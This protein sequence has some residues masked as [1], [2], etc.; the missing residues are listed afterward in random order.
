MT[1]LSEEGMSKTKKCPKL[2]LLHQRVIQVMNAKEKFLKEIKSAAPVNTQMIRKWN[3]LIAD[4]EKVWV[5]WIEDQTSH[6]I[7]WSQSL[8]QS[9]DLIL[10]NLRKA[11]RGEEAAEGKFETSKGWLMRF[12]E[13]NHLYNVKVQEETVN[14]DIE[15]AESCPEDITK[16]MTVPAL[17]T[18]FPM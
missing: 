8:I 3:S 15:T 13:R 18:S 12:K 6:N 16:I 5:V 4:M 1:K 11:E 14:A 2:G 9:K 7:P 17:N 10:P